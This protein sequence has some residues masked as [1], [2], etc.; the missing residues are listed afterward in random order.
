MFDQETWHDQIVDRLNTFAR[1]PF[2]DVQLSG[3]K[4]LFGFLAV[5]TLDPFLEAFQHEPI[6]AVLTLASITRGA[7]ADYLVRQAGRLR[8]QGARQLER[9]L[10][11]NLELC[12]SI[13]QLMV[14][15]N[16]IHLVR[17]RLNSTR[18]EWLRHQL[19]E[20]LEAYRHPTFAKVRHQ[21]EDPGWKLRLE[22]ITNLKH[23]QGHFTP[24]E[25][26]LLSEG[27]NDS[28]SEV[29]SAAAR[30]L[31][32]FAHTPP[33][34]MIKKLVQVAIHDCDMKARRVSALT[35]GN[36]RDRIASPEILE[37][38][39]QHLAD[40]DC[41]VRSATAMLLTELGD[42]A[43]IP[44]I[45]ARLVHLLKDSDAYA[46]EAAAIALGR[47]GTTAVT[48]EVMLALTEAG[49]DSE[50]AVHE[51]AVES[52]LRLRRLRS[53]L[54]PAVQEATKTTNLAR[55]LAESRKAASDTSGNPP[56][57]TSSSTTT[58][59]SNTPASSPPTSPSDGEEKTY[60]AAPRLVH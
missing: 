37:Y 7:G 39:M 8:F 52:L 34:P 9:E 33:T 58:S 51:A 31:G 27:L 47:M 4:T 16:I 35:L 19:T 17:Q 10:S 11:T 57:P 3:G 54:S 46:R 40:P 32:D 49:D 20:E 44:P 42:M 23:R 55:A 59:V 30:R 45:I 21:L 38:L 50:S 28:S 43:G 53:N 26:I 1:N 18:D 29:R 36:L 14:T 15:L 5:R 41:F 2:Q 6:N 56:E 24:A 22:A 48:R 12:G 25:L 60:Q 13:E